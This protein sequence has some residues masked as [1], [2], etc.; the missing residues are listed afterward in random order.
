LGHRCIW[1]ACSA[2]QGVVEAILRERQGS[3]PNPLYL[4]GPPGVGK[5]YLVGLV[6]QQLMAERP[7]LVIATLDSGNLNPASEDED[8]QAI[9]ARQADLVVL[10][11]IQHLS[12]KMVE[13][14]VDLLDRSLKNRHL[15]ITTASAGPTEL[16]N[17]PTRLTSRLAGGLVVE[18]PCWSQASR[19]E[20]LA[21]RCQALGISLDDDTLRTLASQIPGSGRQ[22]EAVARQ[23]GTLDRSRPPGI[24]EIR[25]HLG[26]DAESGRVTLERITQR[27]C[28]YFEVDDR[29]VKSKNR[30]AESLH[31]RQVSMYLARQLTGLSLEQIGNY[32]GGRDHTTVLHACQK[33][34]ED[35]HSNGLLSGAVKTL[36][37]E[38]E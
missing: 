38:F 33:I 32:F 37:G 17:L 22:L 24:E 31:P 3:Q 30:S 8:Q 34:E 7:G 5:S 21:Q 9:A 16:K 2:A 36:R 35:L 18:I 23:I 20:Y 12:P 1:R 6:V 19:Q 10:E 15:L 29:K 14:V 13:K 25:S 11:D 28:R 26:I 27:V 4:H